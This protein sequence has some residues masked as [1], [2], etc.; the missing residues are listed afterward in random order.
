M[1]PLLETPLEELILACVEQRLAEMPQIRWKSGACVS[2]VMSSAGYP[3]DYPKGKEIIGISQA[4]STG[5]VVFHAGTKFD[6]TLVTDGGRVLGV[7]A[8]G[9]N[10]SSAK[11]LAYNAVEKIQ[12]AGAYYRRDISN[13]A[14]A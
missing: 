4:E 10:I 7:T 2:V 11:A 12:F 3:G 14:I 1:L 5:A 6:Q 13:K 8:I 9:E